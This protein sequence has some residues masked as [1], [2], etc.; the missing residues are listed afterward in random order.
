MIRN[1]TARTKIDNFH[2]TPAPVTI[3]FDRHSPGVAADEYILR[4]QVAVDERKAVNV[5]EGYQAMASNFPQSVQ[6]EVQLVSRFS[7]VLV[8]LV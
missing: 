5:L 8:K 7:V 3:T 4:L 1:E 2:F 6:S